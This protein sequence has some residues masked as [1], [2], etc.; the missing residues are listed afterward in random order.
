MTLMPKTQCDGWWEQTGYGRQP[1]TNLIIYFANG[2]LAGS[3]YDIVGRFVLSGHIGQHAIDYHG[4]SAGEGVY[5]GSWSSHGF[6]GGKWSIR[7]R[8]VV[9]CAE[10]AI[11]EIRHP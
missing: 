8:S 2:L 4:V 1:M 9:E 3:G 10:S 7:I 11:T 6:V 5:F